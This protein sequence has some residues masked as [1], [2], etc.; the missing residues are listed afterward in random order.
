MSTLSTEESGT[1]E[2][3]LGEHV[4][5]NDVEKMKD[6]GEER[7]STTLLVA[8]WWRRTSSSRSR[9]QEGPSWVSEP[10]GLNEED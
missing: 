8:P 1:G 9:S 5:E 4:N 10:P 2:F 7:R 3:H 6:G